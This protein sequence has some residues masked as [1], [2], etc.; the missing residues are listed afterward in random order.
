MNLD[1]EVKSDGMLP[2]LSVKLVFAP[3][4]SNVFTIASNSQ[5]TA[6][7]MK[8][9]VLDRF[10]ALSMYYIGSGMVELCIHIP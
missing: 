6:E 1:C 2:S 8:L 7:M 4:E 3:A 5:M 9:S 10:K